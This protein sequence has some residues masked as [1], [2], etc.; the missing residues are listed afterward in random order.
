MAP[1]AS[2]SKAPATVKLT[3][4]EK[5]LIEIG[6]AAPKGQ[7]T[8][9][10]L[11]AKSNLT[12]QAVADAVNSILRKNL[13]QLLRTSTGSV[14]F[15]FIAKEEAKAMGAMDSDEKLVLDH[16]KDA[17]NNGIWT[18]F[19]HNK[20]GLPRTTINKVL[21]TLEGRKVVKTVKSVKHPTRKIYMMSNIAPSVELTGGPW[22]TDNELDME[23]VEALKKITLAY[24]T[25]QVR[26]PPRLK[27]GMSEE[28]QIDFLSFA[29]QTRPRSYKTKNAQ[30]NEL[31]RFPLWPV[32][33]SPRLPRVRDVLDYITESGIAVSVELNDEHV[34]SLL[35]LMIYEGTVERILVQTPADQGARRKK[36]DGAVKKRKRPMVSSDEED[37]DGGARRQKKT[38]SKK[39]VA[40]RRRATNGKARKKSRLDSTALDDDDDDDDDSDAS[41]DFDEDEERGSDADDDAGKSKRKKKVRTRKPLRKVKPEDDDASSVTND[42]TSESSASDRDEDDEEEEERLAALRHQREGGVN[43]YVYRTIREYHPV[44]GWT[45]MPCGK[46][47]VESFCCEPP[48]RF[49]QASAVS[50]SRGSRRPGFLSSGRPKIGI[51]LEGGMKGVGMIGGAGAAIGISTAKWGETKGVVGNGVAPVNPRDCQ[52]FKKWLD[53]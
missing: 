43:D 28:H 38:K 41:A 20:T 44:I 51:E 18:K 37:S 17:N 5:R 21:K 3:A 32:S 4:A 11:L 34:E 46:C 40:G 13:V 29:H 2:T 50:A 1:V 25:K 22:F 39:G 9:A 6:L 30:P 8:Q 27:L 31:P 10:E 47:P 24:L 49:A 23:F 35:E 48:R 12:T 36:K 15:R 52:Y 16:I 26:N 14:E 19:L 45:D 42:S 7:I 53:F 33:A